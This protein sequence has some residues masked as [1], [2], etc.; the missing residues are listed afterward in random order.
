MRKTDAARAFQ[1]SETLMKTPLLSL[2]VIAMLLVVPVR[3]QTRGATAEDYFAFATLGDPRF[4]PDGSTIALSVRLL[5]AVLVTVAFLA[6][7]AAVIWLVM[8]VT[9][10][11]TRLIPLTGRRRGRQPVGDLRRP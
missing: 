3:A 1:A 10:Y 4:S 8:I 2:L 9:L 5:A 6:G 11:I 7:W